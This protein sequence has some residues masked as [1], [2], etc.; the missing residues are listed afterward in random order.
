MYIYVYG[1]DAYTDLR[2]RQ[3][4]Y[5]NYNGMIAPLQWNGIGVINLRENPIKSACLCVGE[6]VVVVSVHC[7]TKHQQNGSDFEDAPS[8]RAD[9]MENKDCKTGNIIYVV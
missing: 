8:R 5:S 4:I 7:D 3:H 9:Q 6:F 2:T 1:W